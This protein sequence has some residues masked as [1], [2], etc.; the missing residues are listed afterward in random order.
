MYAVGSNVPGYAPEADAILVESLEEA[1][2]A[3]SDELER[4]LDFLADAYGVDSEVFDSAYQL[5]V[6]ARRNIEFDVTLPA[7]DS[8]HDLGRVFWIQ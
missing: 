2:H 5:A 4:H 6:I 3:L 8:A 7:S 1:T